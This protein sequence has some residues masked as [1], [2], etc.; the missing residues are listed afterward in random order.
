MSIFGKQKEK[1]KKD[2]F[3]VRYLKGLGV[4][5]LTDSDIEDIE[6]AAAQGDAEAQHDLGKL[7]EVGRGKE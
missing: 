5:M 2:G 7:Y 3:M 4:N 1:K 6:N